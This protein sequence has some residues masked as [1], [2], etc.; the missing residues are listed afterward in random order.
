MSIPSQAPITSRRQAYRLLRPHLVPLA[1]LALAA[2]NAAAQMS[3]ALF[4]GPRRQR[5]DSKTRGLAVAALWTEGAAE[6]VDANESPTMRVFEP[7]GWT[8]LLV[9]NLHVRIQRDTQ[10]PI[11]A[12]RSRRRQQLPDEQL[13][14]P[15]QLNELAPVTNI[16][17]LADLNS[18]GRVSGVYVT[19]PLGKGHAW[20]AIE[21]D[22]TPARRMLVSWQARRVPWLDSITRYE[23]VAGYDDLADRV[24][25]LEAVLG[26]TAHLNPIDALHGEDDQQ[27]RRP[28]FRVPPRKKPQTG[29]GAE[30]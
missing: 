22:L 1:T 13:P 7:Y 17:I 10:R 27:Q 26:R 29:N 23:E 12:R 11:N 19:A 24:K 5:L 6:W 16:D 15:M 14:L 9:G 28:G 20:N 25:R 8:E 3:S 18:D 30:S 21:V 4:R 2:D